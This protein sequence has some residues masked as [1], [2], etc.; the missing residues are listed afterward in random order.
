MKRRVSNL[1]IRRRLQ[2]SLKVDS[3]SK[4]DKGNKTISDTKTVSDEEGVCEIGESRD[5]TYLIEKFK[6]QQV[7]AT[8]PAEISDQDFS[9]QLENEWYR[10]KV[11]GDIDRSGE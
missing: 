8:D 1:A 4:D 10:G 11:L 7:I 3:F 9:N 5:I 6:I 2:N